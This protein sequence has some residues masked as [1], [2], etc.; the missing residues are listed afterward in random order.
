VSNNEWFGVLLALLILAVMF[1]GWIAL[2]LWGIR[3]AKRKNRSPHWMWFGLHPFGLIIVLIVLAAADPLKECPR[4]TRKSKLYARACPY[5]RTSFDGF[6]PA[7][8]PPPPP[9]ISAAEVG[10][11]ETQM[12]DTLMRLC[13][14]YA[15]DNPSEIARL[16]P[17]AL[18]IGEELNRRGGVPEMR[19]MW[20]RLG[21]IRGSRTLDIHWDGI[22]DWRG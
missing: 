13:N 12:Y 7:P 1:G 6:T 17:M 22:G 18:E 14:A 5:C 20:N 11:S 2:V 16:E 19:R 10:M 8:L 9:S 4:C 15:S 3:I 21:N